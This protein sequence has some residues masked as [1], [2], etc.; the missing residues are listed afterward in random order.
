M[1]TIYLAAVVAVAA[2]AVLAL[3]FLLPAT[4]TQSSQTVYLSVGQSGCIAHLSQFNC[5]LILSSRQGAMS[6]S[7]VS[8]VTI[9]DTAAM[10]SVKLIGNGSLS[11]EAD[12]TITTT[13][14]GLPDVNSH[15]PVS[16]GSVVVYLTGGTTV[17]ASVPAQYVE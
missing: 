17:K 7:Q 15:P 13:A 16:S 5:T 1:R 3:V 11:V 12:I 4:G 9:N 2:L 14:G 10:I 8:A 6:G